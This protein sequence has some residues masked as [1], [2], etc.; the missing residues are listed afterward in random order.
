MKL[1]LLHLQQ[2]TT[3]LMLNDGN[4]WNLIFK[5]IFV[6]KLVRTMLLRGPTLVHKPHTHNYCAGVRKMTTLLSGSSLDV[7]RGGGLIILKGA[8]TPVVYYP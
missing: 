2:L 8:A 5:N 1:W 4:L 6:I 7:V 3:I